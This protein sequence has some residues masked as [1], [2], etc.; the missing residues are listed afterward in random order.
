MSIIKV[1][2]LSFTHDASAITLFENIHFTID[3]NWKLGL[4][5]RNGR[6]K[7]TLLQLFMERYEYSGQIHNSVT[8]S[9][10][11]YSVNEKELTIDIVGDDWRIYKELS[12]LEVDEGVLYRPFHTL[13]SGEQTKVLLAALFVKEHHFLLIDEPTNHLDQEGRL[14][15]SAYLKKKKGF[16]LVSHDRYFMDHCVDH[17]MS[18]NKTHIEIVKGNFS[19]WHSNKANQ[20]QLEREHNKKL[21]KEINRLNTTSKEKVVWSDRIEKSKSRKVNPEALDKGYIGHQAAKMMKRAKTIENRMHKQIQEKEGLLKDLEY[22]SELKINSLK[23]HANRL[24]E[25][26]NLN[27]YY[28][29]NCIVS[30]LD[31]TLLQ[32]HKIHLKGS[33]GSGKSSLIKLILGEDIAY[34]GRLYKSK[35]LTI[36]YISQDISHLKG[37]LAMF[38]KR[39]Q[40]DVT[41]FKTIL[42]KLDFTREHFTQNL[43]TYSAGQKKK[44][45]IAASLATQAHLYI[46]DEP[47]NYIDVIS[48]VQI[49]EVIKQSVMTLLFVEHDKMFSDAIADGVISLNK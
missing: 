16:I 28:D 12:L 2:D 22:T 27:I 13:S 14:L 42:R 4:I 10:F 8:F 33:N 19:S 18:I 47:L 45:L 7:T 29:E 17:I 20:E 1:N 26:K 15:L 48:R 9:Y 11:P 38:E 31:F 36:S 30:N 46:W 25:A 40:L 44:V 32:G 21:T 23:Y 5:G 39:E 35:G 41:L 3:T 43:E 24:L 37:S 6:G 34:C 49:E